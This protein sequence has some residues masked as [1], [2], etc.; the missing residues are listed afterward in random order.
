MSCLISCLIN[1]HIFDYPDS[2]LS[3]LFTLV[4]PSPDNRGST[5]CNIPILFAVSRIISQGSRFPAISSDSRINFAV[6]PKQIFLELAPPR[7]KIRKTFLNLI[8]FCDVCT[9]RQNKRYLTL[10]LSSVQK[11]LFQ[12]TQLSIS[13]NL[14]LKSTVS[15]EAW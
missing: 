4:P 14:K 2:R 6:L 8:C 7:S 11:F 1:I 9:F 13:F 12:W 5:V 10:N 3:G 15:H